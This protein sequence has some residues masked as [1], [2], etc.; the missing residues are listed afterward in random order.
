MRRRAWRGAGSSAEV[1][2][3][4]RSSLRFEGLGDAGCGL[5]VASPHRKRRMEER[6]KHKI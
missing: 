4:C 2:A 1:Q 3:E 5:C 6:I